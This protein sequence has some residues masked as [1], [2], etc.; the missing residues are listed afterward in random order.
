M[1][2]LERGKLVL[3]GESL[4]TWRVSA[5]VSIIG[6]AD[7][8]EG[9]RVAFLRQVTAHR[10]L[11]E[12]K[13]F[14]RGCNRTETELQ[15]SGIRAVTLQQHYEGQISSFLNADS[16]CF[17]FYHP[18]L[19]RNE[20]MNSERADASTTRNIPAS[21]LCLSAQAVATMTSERL[22]RIRLP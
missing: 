1:F 11:A 15:V 20:R 3:V 2:S 19:N 14:T 22:G 4:E 8:Q 18:H 7:G 5:D 6:Q 16:S 21:A 13:C 9:G 17:K 12:M 10:S